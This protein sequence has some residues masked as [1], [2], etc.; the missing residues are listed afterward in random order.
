MTV[1]LPELLMDTPSNKVV[2]AF[3]LKK[4]P[5]VAI[6]LWLAIVKFPVICTLQ[7]FV[8]ISLCLGPYFWCGQG[9]EFKILYVF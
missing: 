3:W 1:N 4:A 2:L 5:I 6:S 8:N 9:G 7:D